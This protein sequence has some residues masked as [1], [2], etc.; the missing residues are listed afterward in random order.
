M[1]FERPA[2]GHLAT[3]VEVCFRRS[4]LAGRQ[5]R[6]GEFRELVSSASLVCAGRV[7]A[8]RDA[9]H[10]RW[11]IGTGKVE[12]LAA[13]IAETSS[14]V[15]IFDHELTPAQQRNLETRLEC[16]VMTRTELILH[17]FADRARTREGQLQ[18]ALAQLAHA[19]TRLV[20]GWAHLD[21]QSGVGGAGGQGA[22]GRVGAGAARGVGE[23]QLELDQRMIAARIRQVRERLAS[24]Q[25]HRA[26]SRRRR[27]KAR[28]PTVALAGYTNA[29]K[30]TLFNALTGGGAEAADR[31]FATLDPTLRRLAGADAEV[32]VADT[33]GFIRD[34]PHTLVE[35]FKATLEEVAEADLVLHVIDAAA[36]DVDDS[37]A[38][39]RR[40]LA[41]IGAGDV[42]AVEVWN[43]TD[44]LADPPPPSENS[45]AVSALTGAGIDR[46][47]AAVLKNL[48]LDLVAT[49]LQLPPTAGKL[50]PWLHE[51]GRVVDETVA[52]DGSMTVDVRLSPAQL[53]RWRAMAGAAGCLPSPG[54][55]VT[56]P[57]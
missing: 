33:V 32:V 7:S 37:R 52:A 4:G 46:L 23:T 30:S 49:R 39:V 34:L 48:G 18:V 44:L 5:A 55:A 15:A 21:R 28:V 36:P 43:K 57:A 35:A 24:V 25:K 22:G 2:P 54:R 13:A 20:R 3:L 53:R 1:L 38:V 50:R 19:Q 12:E 40:T 10:P 26:Q 8:T 29:G 17:I 45:V 31:L 27:S 6:P 51:H 14:T 16:R 41:E 56:A 11:F 9:P 42:P 47:K